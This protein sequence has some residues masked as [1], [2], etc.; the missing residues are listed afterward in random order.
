MIDLPFEQERPALNT[1]VKTADDNFRANW[2]AVETA[3][4]RQHEFEGDNS[5]DE[6]QH[7]PGKVSV[8]QVAPTSAVSAYGLSAAGGPSVEGKGAIVYDTWAKAF[9]TWNGSAWSTI[10]HAKASGDTLDTTWT[11]DGEFI[12]G[13]DP[14]VDGTKLDTISCSADDISI[15]HGVAS[16]GGSVEVADGYTVAN[17]AIFMHNCGV[18]SLAPYQCYYIGCSASEVPYASLGETQVGWKFKS[19]I[20]ATDTN[21]SYPD[22]Y[23]VIISRRHST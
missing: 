22:V 11:V 2:D 4:S 19:L 16:H 9:K 5:D 17:S 18:W 6:G 21:P 8:L 23:F 10:D 15:T 14:S 12:D 1:K 3:G 13:R 7:I 20:M